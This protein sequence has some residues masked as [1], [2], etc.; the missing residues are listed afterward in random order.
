ML[1]VTALTVGFGSDFA[2]TT[3]AARILMFPFSLATIAALATQVSGIIAF[4]SDRAKK[5]KQRWRSLYEHTEH[6]AYSKM[7]PT[8]ELLGEMRLL[9][10]I[11]KQED[12]ISRAYD[13]SISV[14]VFALFWCLGA[15]AFHFLEVS[16][17]AKL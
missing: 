6:E 4:F 8:T 10:R 14:A 11:S 13:L 15:L 5:R 17:S 12:A 9:D 1:Q 3:K 7:H 16:A 2:P